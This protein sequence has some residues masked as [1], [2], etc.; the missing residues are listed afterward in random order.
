MWDKLIDKVDMFSIFTKE[1]IIK[2]VGQIL[3]ENS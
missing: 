1:E 3:L 2:E